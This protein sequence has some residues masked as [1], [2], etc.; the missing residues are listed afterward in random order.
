MDTVQRFIQS[1]STQYSINIEELRQ[2]WSSLQKQLPLSETYLKTLRLSL[3]AEECN[4]R[5][6]KKSGTKKVLIERLL[7]C[8]HNQSDLYSKNI[9]Q[10]K[11]LC[12]KHNLHVTGSKQVL[13]SRLET[14]VFCTDEER[15]K[16]LNTQIIPKKN[17]IHQIILNHESYIDM[18]INKMRCIS[19]N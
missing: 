14:N 12:K 11:Q 19:A 18:F 8:N 13:I 7:S 15:K 5:G 16:T 4:K 10:L 6:L 2:L 3:L 1:I 17:N 9:Q